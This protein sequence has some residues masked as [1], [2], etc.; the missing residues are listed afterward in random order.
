MDDNNGVDRVSAALVSAVEVDEEE[1]ARPPTFSDEALAL[2][3]ADNHA[4]DLRYV[5]FWSRWFRYDGRVWHSDNTL[6]AFDAVR[7]VCREAA[8]ECDLQRMARAVASAKTVAA[9]ERLAK[10]DRRLAAPHD[11]WD[12]DDWILNTPDGVVDL[13]NGALRQHAV[14][15]YATKI[16]AVGPAAKTSCPRWSKFLKEIT[17][18]DSDLARFLQRMAG[19]ALTGD[20][21]AQ[22]LFFGHGGGANGKGTFTHTIAGILGDYHVTTPIETFTATSVDRHPTE[23]ADLRGARLV[24]ANETESGRKW[25]ESRIKTLTGGD[26]VKAR[27]MRQDFFTFM[28]QFK[29]LITGNHKPRLRSVDE[30]MRRRLNLIPFLVTIPA[31]KRDSSLEVKLKKEWPAILQWM[32]EGCLEWQ[33][34]GLAPPPAVTQATEEYLKAEDAFGLWMEDCCSRV[35]GAWTRSADLFG[36][37]KQWATDAN[38]LVGGHNQFSQ[39]LGEHGFRAVARHGGR[40]FLGLALVSAPSSDLHDQRGGLDEI[41]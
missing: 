6:F 14:E 26:P 38:E 16:T 33:R 25:A 5:A 13:R 2:R 24:T 17:A 1:I 9:V 39:K 22:A 10:A 21:S 20:V 7:R 41:P 30:A 32:I 28:P 36:S 35:P 15:D 11:L 23:L 18:G 27:L 3:F 12:R 8:A 31:N 19:Y 34:M 40:G 4:A 29:L 37:W